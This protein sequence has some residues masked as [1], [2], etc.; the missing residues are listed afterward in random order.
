MLSPKDGD[1]F[2]PPRVAWTGALILTFVFTIAFVHRIGLSLYVEP[3]KA[4]LGLSDTEIGILT[5]IAFAL[6]YTLGGLMCGWLAD[7][8]HRIALLALSAAIWSGATVALGVLGSFAH[9]VGAR[10]LTGLG[11]AAVQPASASL[12]A[13]LFAPARRGRAYGLFIAATAFGTAGAFGLG[14]ATVALGDRLGPALG[15]AGWRAGLILLGALGFTALGALAFAREP[16]RTDRAAGRP[17]T[18]PELAR[19]FSG[20]AKVLATLYVGVTFAFLA[21]Y[22]Q[23]AFMPALFA[24]KFGWSADQLALAYGVIAVVGG[25]GGALAGGWLADRWRSRGMVG[26]AWLLCLCGSFL[27]LILATAAPLVDSGWASLG[28]FGAAALFANWPSIGALAVI[29]EITPNEL[30]G[31]VTAGHTAMIGL[32]AAGLGP[33]IVGMLTDRLFGSAAD[34]DRSLALTFAVCTVVATVSLA[35]GYGAF[36]ST[37]LLRA[38]GSH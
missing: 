33:V 26:S 21:P 9:M 19:F 32:I 24:R 10:V 8:H 37:A 18:L 35:A 29:A 30:R 1:G 16:P 12:L 14:A 17:S 15:I 5:G 13:D 27:S 2:P 11:Q 7:R 34:L 20:N 28:W 38:N 3:I 22:G 6:P 23:L 4:A 36:R 31:Q 25:A